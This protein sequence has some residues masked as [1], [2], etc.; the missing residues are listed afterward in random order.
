[1]RVFLLQLIEL[2]I[3]MGLG[4]LGCYL[5]GRMIPDSS[6][7]TMIYHPGTHLFAAGDVL[8]LTI[9][10]IAWMIFRGYSPQLSLETAASMIAPVAVI[11]VLGESAGIAYL[12]WL[13]M[14]MYPVM[15]LGILVY[16]LYRRDDFTRG[17]G[18][19]SWS[20]RYQES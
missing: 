15:C 16:M 8:F 18:N 9:P 7:F 3:P 19:P 11:A 17:A 12:L 13:V 14:A 6:S 20:A 5:L 4:A 2:Q 10:V 1:M